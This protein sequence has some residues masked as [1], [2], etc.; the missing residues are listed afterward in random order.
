[1]HT[2]HFRRH[3][4]NNTNVTRKKQTKQK[5]TRRK[6]KHKNTKLKT[7]R[8]IPVRSTKLIWEKVPRR[9][10]TGD[11]QTARA[12]EKAFDRMLTPC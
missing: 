4:F 5:Q 1:M 12:G 2:M 7:L 8:H 3:K 9:S 10:K 6:H 11:G